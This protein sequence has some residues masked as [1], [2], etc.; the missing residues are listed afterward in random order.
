MKL[1][2]N[3][4]L[5]KLAFA[6]YVCKKVYGDE[7]YIDFLSYTN[8][9]PNLSK[10]E[11]CQALFK[12][13][14]RWYCRLRKDDGK[15]YCDKTCKEIKSWYKQ[16]QN[17]LPDEE[18]NLLEL[19]EQLDNVNCAYEDLKNRS[20]GIRKIGKTAASKILFAIRPNSLVPWD[21]KIRDKL[22]PNG[23]YREFLE[24]MQTMVRDIKQLC[25]NQGFKLA[26]LPEKLGESGKIQLNG[27]TILKTIPKIIDEYNWITITKNCKPPSRETLQ[28]WIDWC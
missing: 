27:Q 10:D 26:E 17:K 2:E 22:C 7:A 9:C 3:I 23:S 12:F 25:K 6:C 28:Q 21:N 4:T 5:G 11:H 19:R 8:K 20:A 16:Y 18:I 14:N 13:L 1:G 15:E 24:K